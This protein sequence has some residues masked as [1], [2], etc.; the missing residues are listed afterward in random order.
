MSDWPTQAYKGRGE[1][2]LE[3]RDG[4]DVVL[5]GRSTQNPILCN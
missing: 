5:G 4:G 1:R 3:T 2:D